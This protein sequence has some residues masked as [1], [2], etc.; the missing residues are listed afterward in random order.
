[1]GGG[2]VMARSPRPLRVKG[3]LLSV[4]CL[5]RNS[6]LSPWPGRRAPLFLLVKVKVTGQNKRL[7]KHICAVQEGVHILTLD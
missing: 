6:T 5:C 7:K 2:G 4:C 3:L 1:M